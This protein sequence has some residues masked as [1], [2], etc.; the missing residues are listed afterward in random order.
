MAHLQTAAPVR[1]ASLREHNLALV[2]RQVTGRRTV[3]RADIATATGLTRATVSAL[4]D[5]L[6][7]GRLV[8]EVAPAPKAGAGR[9]S[10]GLALDARGP[11]GLGLESTSTISRV[12]AT[13]AVRHREVV[14]EDRR[15]R[16]QTAVPSPSS[17]AASGAAAADAGLHLAGAALA[18]PG[19]VQS[20]GAVGTQL[21]WQ[22]P[23]PDA[24]RRCAVRV[25]KRPTWRRSAR[26]SNPHAG[27]SFI[28]VSGEVG[29]GAGIVLG[30]E[31][32]RARASAARSAM[33]RSPT[34]TLPSR[35]VDCMRVDS[36]T[37]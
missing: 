4:V 28:C 36:S 30:G 35:A 22:R 1:Q 8:V 20:D 26:C 17:V 9:P 29:I 32:T 3:S 2:L 21:G 14:R 15:P 33:S 24:G 19:L 23:D 18:A 34:A 7:A 13:G 10:V 5:D 25:D 27:R 16:T 11:A 12:V 6:I 37:R 31:A